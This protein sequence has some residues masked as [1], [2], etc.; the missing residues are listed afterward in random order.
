MM[1]SA[2]ELM[3]QAPWTMDLYLTE[4]IARIDR[5]LGEGYAKKNPDLLAAFM[6]GC[7]VDFATA[8]LS[9][10]LGDDIANVLGDIVGAL[11]RALEK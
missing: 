11:E 3:K 4:G 6:R 5:L 7:T 9:R 2:D 1:P 8:M 10:A